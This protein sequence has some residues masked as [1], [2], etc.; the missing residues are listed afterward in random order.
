M[1][2]KDVANMKIFIT[3]ENSFKDSAK[4]KE[5]EVICDLNFAIEKLEEEIQALWYWLIAALSMKSYFIMYSVTGFTWN[6]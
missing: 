2:T 6:T 1:E 3:K 4:K 5:E